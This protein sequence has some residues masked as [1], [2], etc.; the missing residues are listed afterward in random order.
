MERFDIGGHN[1][2]VSYEKL[3][4]GLKGWTSPKSW[5]YIVLIDRSL[6]PS[7]AFRQL[8]SEVRQIK[9]YD[10]YGDRAKKELENEAEQALNRPQLLL[11]IK[12]AIRSAYE[13]E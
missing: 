10:S 1:V 5:G 13:L 2:V 7:D 12:E 9:R 11:D 8:L 6:A 3:P 4:H